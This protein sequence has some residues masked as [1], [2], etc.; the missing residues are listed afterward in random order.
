MGHPR[1]MHGSAAPPPELVLPSCAAASSAWLSKMRVMGM[2]T[3]QA[4]GAMYI[5][6]F[7]LSSF[8]VASDSSMPWSTAGGGSAGID[9]KAGHMAC[10]AS[11]RGG[12]EAFHSGTL[13]AF[14]WL[15]LAPKTV[16]V[17]RAL[18]PDRTVSTLAV[19]VT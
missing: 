9:F 2:S 16:R 8:S 7:M 1:P 12:A 6:R 14:C 5:S 18:K 11:S 4:T 10:V 13:P 15:L 19:Y 17:M 3:R